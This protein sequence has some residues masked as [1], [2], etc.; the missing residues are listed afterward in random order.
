MSCTGVLRRAP[1]GWQEVPY[2]PGDS[3]LAGAVPDV[4]IIIYRESLWH[5]VTLKIQ[6]TAVVSSSETVAA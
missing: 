1:W 5:D 4:K 3:G 6:C 2:P